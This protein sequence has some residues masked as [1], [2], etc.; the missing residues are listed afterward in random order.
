[1]QDPG[2]ELRR[3]V[4]MRGSRRRPLRAGPS[5][6]GPGTA[7]EEGWHTPGYYVE[8]SPA[9]SGRGLRGWAG[10]ERG[11]VTRYEV[12][13]IPSSSTNMMYGS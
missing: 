6:A 11:S 4:L 5:E 8:G 12:S 10:A 7:V 9:R 1:M 13:S 3:I 2:C